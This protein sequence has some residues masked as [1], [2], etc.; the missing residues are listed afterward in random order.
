MDG[1]VV[2]TY[3]GDVLH[4]V[5]QALLAPDIILLLAFI[6]YALFCIGSVV[7]ERFSERRHFKVVMPKFLADLMAAKED[8]IPDVIADSGLLKRQKAALQ[9]VYDYR[10]LPGDALVA[11][12]RRL[13][14]EEETRYDRIT[15]RNNMAARVAPML[16]LMGTLI[17]LGPGIQALG[18]ADTAALSSS[19][20]VAFDTTVAGLVAAAVCMVVGKIRSNWYGNYMSALDSAMATMQQKIEDM[21]SEGAVSV[22][23]PSDYAFLYGDKGAAPTF[24]STPKARPASGPSTRPASSSPLPAEDNAPAARPATRPDASAARPTPADMAVASAERR[25]ARTFADPLPS[26]MGVP[27]YQQEK[28]QA[29]YGVAPANGAIGAD[30]SATQAAPA[31]PSAASAAA[32][33]A[34]PSAAAPSPSS[35][36]P[37]GR[38]GSADAA[39]AEAGASQARQVAPAIEEVPMP[40]FI[41]ALAQANEPIAQKLA[42]ESSSQV[43]GQ[44]PAVRLDVQSAAMSAAQPAARQGDQPAMQPAVQAGLRSDAQQMAHSAAPASSD[45]NAGSAPGWYQP[46]TQQA[47]MPAAAWAPPS[48]QAVYPN[49]DASATPEAPAG[50]DAGDAQ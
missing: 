40:A 48:A 33:A 46:R 4:A 2:Q 41:D 19:L 15:G 6:A 35:T 22:Q 12:I 47:P 42:N 34:V 25:S 30:E 36:A 3:L 28:V 43:T 8:E 38:V 23:E 7:A 27:A 37:F 20:L 5:S 26:Q 13:V 14:S 45:A 50:G 24:G 10:I 31:S 21:R 11:L 17:P 44:I 49:Y 32:S 16:G 1:S 39:Y 29:G 18:Q 9:T